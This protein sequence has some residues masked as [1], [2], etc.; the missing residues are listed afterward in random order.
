MGKGLND[1]FIK[2]DRIAKNWIYKGWVKEKDKTIDQL[3]DSIA[4]RFRDILK[5]MDFKD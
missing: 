5:K 3:A 4:R 1:C 2:T